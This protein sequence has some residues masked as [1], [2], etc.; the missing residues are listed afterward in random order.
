MRRHPQSDIIWDKLRNADCQEC[1]LCEENKPDKVCLLGDGP[2]PC[3]AMIVGEGPGAREAELEIPFSGKSGLLLRRTLKEIGIDPREIYITNVV[4][5][6]PPGNRTPTRKEINTCSNLY[7]LDQIKVVKPKVI[8]CLGNVAIHFAKGKKEAVTKIE[9]TTFKYK[10]DSL[11]PDS[12]ICVPSRHPSSVLRAEDTR[13]FPF[14]MNKFREN[15][16]LFKKMLNPPEKEEF[17]FIQKPVRLDDNY[18]YIYIDIE[19]NGLNPFK[20][21]AKIH[22]AAIVQKEEV[23]AF[24][25]RRKVGKL[26]VSS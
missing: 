14:I 15:L 16:I 8:L 25:L 3:D 5:C 6:R 1:S 4:A 10:R 19:T 21:G 17:E 18:P 2:V 11:L 23:S 13:E 12:T 22:C 20:E 26:P 9:G 7:L 24:M